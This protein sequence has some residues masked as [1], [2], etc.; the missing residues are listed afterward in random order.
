MAKSK[1]NSVAETAYGGIYNTLR[2]LVHLTAAVQF[3][4]AIYYDR[5]YLRTF[6]GV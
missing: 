6:S 2:I 4:Y 1:V 5:S 3:S